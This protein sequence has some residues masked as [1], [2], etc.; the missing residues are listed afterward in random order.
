MRKFESSQKDESK[1]QSADWSKPIE[2]LLER[3]NVVIILHFK[4]WGG[5]HQDFFDH[6]IVLR[7]PWMAR[8]AKNFF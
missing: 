2:N 1:A 7:M 5:A 8:K 3:L 4:T 6:T